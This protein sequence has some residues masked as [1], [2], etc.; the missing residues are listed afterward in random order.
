MDALYRVAPLGE[1]EDARG[2]ALVNFY[3]AR[4]KRED[5]TVFLAA[6]QA[7]ERGERETVIVQ[8]R[9]G[10]AHA[11]VSTWP[12]FDLVHGKILRARALA[13]NETPGRLLHETILA[14]AEERARVLGCGGVVMEL[15][16]DA[17]AMCRD[18]ESSVRGAGFSRV[19][20]AYYRPLPRS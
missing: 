18:L 14:A 9:R 20:A 3:D 16:G 4:V 7:I 8:D 13:C 1:D 11:V 6:E 12:D 5:W 17:A 2:F 15:G 10:Y 19:G